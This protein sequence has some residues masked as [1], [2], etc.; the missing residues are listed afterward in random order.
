LHG[1]ADRGANDIAAFLVAKGAR[2]NVKDKD[3]R[4]AA[5]VAKGDGGRGHPEYPRT[6]ELLT[7]LAAEASKGDK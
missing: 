6:V 5:D 2:L 4:T 7:R 1:A 3:G